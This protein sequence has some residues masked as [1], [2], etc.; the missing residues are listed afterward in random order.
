MFGF[1]RLGTLVGYYDE[2]KPLNEY[3]LD[4]LALF[5]GQDWEQE[6]DITMVTLTYDGG[7]G[8]ST[9]ANVNP[10]EINSPISKPETKWE[11]LGEWQIASAPGNERAGMDN[12]AERLKFL[13]LPARTLDRLK[14]AVAETIMNAMEHGN[15][16]QPDKLVGLKLKGSEQAVMVSVTDASSGVLPL[17]AEEP[18]LEAKLAGLQ[19]PRGWGLFLIEKMVDELRDYHDEKT[20]THTVELIVRW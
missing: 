10:V 2:E 15:H 8:V 12:V 13:N 11:S 1:P 18:D 20:G 19:T 6:D 9:I 4:R 16:Y 7:Q 3:L 14:T 17:L 5:T